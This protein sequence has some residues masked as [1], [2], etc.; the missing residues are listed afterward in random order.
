MKKYIDDTTALAHR[1]KYVQTLSGRRRYVP[2]LDSGNAQLRQSAERAAVNMPIQ[3]TA[4]DIIK[5]AMIAVQKYLKETCGNGCT[6]LLQVHDE[7]LFEV[8]EDMVAIVT[9]EIMRLMESAFPLDVPLR[10]DAK[11]GLSWAEMSIS[12]KR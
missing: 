6:L 3:G 9:P 2:E 7:L 11:S 4:A 1:Q 8:E 5:I 10:A 12:T